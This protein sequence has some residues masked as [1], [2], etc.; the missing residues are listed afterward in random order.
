M[1]NLKLSKVWS[2]AL[3]TLTLALTLLGCNRKLEPTQY[4]APP[5][6]ENSSKDLTQ[7]LAALDAIPVIENQ[8]ATD[9]L[10]ILNQLVPRVRYESQLDVSFDDL[11]RALSLG[12]GVLKKA[13]W[14]VVDCALAG[15]HLDFRSPE[16]KFRCG[17]IPYGR[18]LNAKDKEIFNIDFEGLSGNRN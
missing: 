10:G 3:S 4:V 17:E 6:Y 11:S 15:G 9:P 5:A 8:A 16:K 1:N 12:E 7:M 18:I 13:L 14:P 2:F